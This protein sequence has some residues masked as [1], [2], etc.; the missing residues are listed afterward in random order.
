MEEEKKEMAKL[1][2]KLR[3]SNAL[4]YVS[5]DVKENVKRLI[6]RKYVWPGHKNLSKDELELWARETNE[7]REIVLEILESLK[8]PILR[9]DS[10]Q[11]INSNVSRTLKFISTIVC[12][13]LNILSFQILIYG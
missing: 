11:N 12:N 2:P 8:V 4:I 5:C 3:L 13:V 7:R 6:S 9:I 1:I 10:A